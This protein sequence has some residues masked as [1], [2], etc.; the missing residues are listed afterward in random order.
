MSGNTCNL[1]D[2]IAEN[3]LIGQIVNGIHR[4][5]LSIERIIV[6]NSMHPIGHNTR[7]PI[8]AMD[9]IRRPIEEPQC[10]QNTATEQ[11]EALAIICIAINILALKIARRV[12][13]IDRNRI[14]NGA[15]PYAD[16]HLKITHIY[17]N[18]VHYRFE[19]ETLWVHLPITRHS[20][21]NV[22]TQSL[23]GFWQC[24]YYIGQA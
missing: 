8:M 22:M 11:D 9:N 10:F 16:R 17:G 14:S 18:S 1:Q 20:Q 13:H 23:E 7:M 15:S 12:N 3:P 6:I 19:V 24:S 21:A 5:S 4:G 2:A